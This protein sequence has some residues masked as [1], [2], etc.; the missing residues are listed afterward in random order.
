[1]A[2]TTGSS[3]GFDRI[4][5]APSVSGIPTA[6]TGLA[7]DSGLGLT[8]LYAA[9]AA[10]TSLPESVTTNIDGDDGVSDQFLFDATELEGFSLSLGR[11][12]YGFINTIQGTTSID[13]QSTYSML[14]RNPKG[15]DFADMFFLL[16]RRAQKR[17]GTTGS[18]YEHLIVPKCNGTYLSGPF[19][20]RAAGVYNFNVVAN[21]VDQTFY[22]NPLGSDASEVGTKGE[23]SSF[24]FFTDY[25]VTIDVYKSNGVA[26]SYTPSQAPRTSG[27]VI[28]WDCG[29]LALATIPTTLAATE[30]SGSF[31]FTAPGSGDHIIFLYEVAE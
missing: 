9:Q 17:D 20:A 10:D 13:M 19:G 12:N 28:A 30:S 26:T 15:R 11:T 22:G 8:R 16:T 27:T 31:T 18:G 7:A 2:T 29:D 3:A 14:P 21:T 6:Y 1:M 23:V 4:Q 5:Y 24:E 25:R